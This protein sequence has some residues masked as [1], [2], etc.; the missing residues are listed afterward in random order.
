MPQ[1]F[2]RDVRRRGKARA[3]FRLLEAEELIEAA[4]RRFPIG[5]RHGV[6]GFDVG[7]RVR[8]GLPTPEHTLRLYIEQK[9]PE[10]GGTLNRPF[11]V[12]AS[13]SLVVPDIVATGSRPRT[14]EGRSLTFSGVHVGAAILVAKRHFGGIGAILT[15]NTK[16]SHLLTA[17]HLFPEGSTDVAVQA[18]RSGGSPRIVG[19]LACNL[20]DKHR[21]SHAIDAAL[22]RLND[23][24]SELAVSNS[25]TRPPR[26][27][28]L[29][30]SDP[31][32]VVVQA[33]LSTA[34]DFSTPSK[35]SLLPL[36]V[37]LL[38]GA[39]PSGY[40]VRGVVRCAHEITR[41]GD[42]GTAFLTADAQRH[43][44]GTCV[45]VDGKGSLVEPAARALAVL[46][47][48]TGLSLN[49]WNGS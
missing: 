43:L 38:S 14:L 2:D 11:K 28:A 12:G 18:A 4:L 20:L 49:L 6:F 5:N 33:Y 8:R 48:E 32:D 30:S 25:S 7:V 22:V 3:G 44:V 47:A 9:L 31:E 34:L 37:H 23:L 21:G 40:T 45:G 39:R 36:A 29:F 27:G 17:G 16:P 1:R 46:A 24:G 15:S 26:P 13:R 35:M 10:S 19:H 41:Q 42:S